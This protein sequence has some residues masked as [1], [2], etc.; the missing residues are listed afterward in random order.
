MQTLQDTQKDPHSVA[1]RSTSVPVPIPI[2]VT[3]QLKEMSRQQISDSPVFGAD[4][5]ELR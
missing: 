4:T 2:N 5:Q 1:E 3:T